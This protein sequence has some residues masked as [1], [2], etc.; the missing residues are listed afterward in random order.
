[1]IQ[2][3]LVSE[4]KEYK[5]YALKFVGIFAKNRAEWVIIDFASILYGF[6]AVPFYETLGDSYF[7]LFVS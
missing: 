7:F 1:M 3:N 4:T 5:D 2:Q 6:T